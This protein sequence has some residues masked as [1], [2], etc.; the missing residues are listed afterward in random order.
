[1]TGVEMEGGTQ[2]VERGAGGLELPWDV[3]KL[4]GAVSRHKARVLIG[5]GIV[6]RLSDYLANRGYFLDEAALVGNISGKPIFGVFSTLG[7]DQLA[8]PGF[9]VV[10]RFISGLVSNTSF[11]LRLLPLIC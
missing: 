11:G 1:M 4:L 5:I 8:P 6:L 9:L 3:R 10:E 7:G 2:E